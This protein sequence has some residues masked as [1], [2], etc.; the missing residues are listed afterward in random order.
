MITS[1]GN[2]GWPGDDLIGDLAGTGL[3]D[4][5]VVRTAKIAN[6]ELRGAERVGALGE[7]KMAEV[8]AEL[9]AILGFRTM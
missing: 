2:A 5:S 1:A 7:R 4:P 8:E 3:L 9:R 6:S